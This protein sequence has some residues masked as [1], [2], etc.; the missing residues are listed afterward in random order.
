MSLWLLACV[1]VLGA[2]AERSKEG[3]LALYA[4]CEPSGPILRDLSGVSPSLPLRIEHMERV[5]R[6]GTQLKVTGDTRIKGLALSKELVQ[7][8]SLIHI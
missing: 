4:F 5:Q 8:L 1:G 6:E 3:L 7:V 2:K